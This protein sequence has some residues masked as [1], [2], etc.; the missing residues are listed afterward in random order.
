VLRD[1]DHAIIDTNLT[2]TIRLMWQ[3]AASPLIGPQSQR[4]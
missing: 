1:P 4:A 2:D 3:R